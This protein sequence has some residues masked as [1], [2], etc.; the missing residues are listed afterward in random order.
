MQLFIP[1]RR[2]TRGRQLRFR[3]RKNPETNGLFIS[4]REALLGVLL[5]TLSVLALHWIL[6]G[7]A[8][9]PEHEDPVSATAYRA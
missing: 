9:S 6:S 1:A 4:K 2:R 8:M 3:F 5:L 7:S